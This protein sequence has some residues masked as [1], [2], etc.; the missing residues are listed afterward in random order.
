MKISSIYIYI[1]IFVNASCQR[2]FVTVIAFPLF[3][4]LYMLEK[5][6]TSIG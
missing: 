4:F 6:L 1:V 5:D 3:V 2:Y